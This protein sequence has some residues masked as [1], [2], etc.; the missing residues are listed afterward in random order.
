VWSDNLDPGLA[1]YARLL[2]DAANAAGYPVRV[3]STRRTRVQQ[4]RLYR[5]Y[6]AG[7]SPYPAAPPGA[8]KHEQG[9]AF[10]VTGP[11]EVL[12]AMGELWESWGGTWGGRFNDPIHFEV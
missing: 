11:P 7:L 5:R 3:T 1:P 4:A 8:S 12:A 9:L 6:L 2:V 10:D